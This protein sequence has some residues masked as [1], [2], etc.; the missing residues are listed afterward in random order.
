MPVPLS[1]KIPSTV[2]RLVFIFP[3]QVLVD[4]PTSGLVAKVTGKGICH[5]V[6]FLILDLSQSIHYWFL[7]IYYKQYYPTN[8]DNF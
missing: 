4:A 3:P 6:Y 5:N 2:S 8:E 7:F 1:T